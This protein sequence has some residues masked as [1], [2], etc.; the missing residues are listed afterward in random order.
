MSPILA[1][2]LHP[3]LL[4]VRRPYKQPYYIITDT[5]EAEDKLRKRITKED[6]QLKF[7]I[8]RSVLQDF[9]KEFKQCRFAFLWYKVV[10]RRYR[11]R[12]ISEKAV[13]W[14][15]FNN[16][17]ASQHSATT[18]FFDKFI[19]GLRKL[20]DEISLGPLNR[21]V[22]LSALYSIYLT[23][24]HLVHG[25]YSSSIKN[26]WQFEVKRGLRCYLIDCVQ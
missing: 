24:P 19:A 11:D 18:V 21:L 4:L 6:H 7:I 5:Y 25:K 14:S 26:R 23:I 22:P 17:R 2:Q 12:G 20:I 3:R 10:A 9:A 13:F 15:T 1:L 8:A 16:L